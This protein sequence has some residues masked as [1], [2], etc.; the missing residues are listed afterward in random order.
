VR[1]RLA[2]ALSQTAAKT[3]GRIA[4]EYNRADIAWLTGDPVRN[5]KAPIAIIELKA[6]YAFDLIAQPDV[7]MKYLANDLQ[8]AAKCGGCTCRCYAILLATHPKT[9]VPETVFDTVKYARKINAALRL[10]ES[11]NAVSRRAVEEV[12]MRLPPNSAVHRFRW[13]LGSYL[14]IEV[15]LLGWLIQADCRDA[16]INTGQFA[17]IIHAPAPASATSSR[18][19]STEDDG[20]SKP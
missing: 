1:D 8:K 18:D 13:S 6:C 16:S 19:A 5:R 12:E 2:Y 11:G 15:D 4:R 7:Y 17:V 9:E 14:G 20:D 10:C 3:G